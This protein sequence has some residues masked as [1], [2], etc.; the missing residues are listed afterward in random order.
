M[1][2]Q[3]QEIGEV[4]VGINMLPPAVLR[5]AQG[6]RTRLLLAGRLRE[7]SGECA[8][9]SGAL[10]SVFRKLIHPPRDKERNERRLQ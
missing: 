3:A 7:G 6:N 5:G 4:G 8:L 10:G 1:F 2:E 9:W